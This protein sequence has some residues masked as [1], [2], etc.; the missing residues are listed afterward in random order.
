MFFPRRRPGLAG[1]PPLLP[2]AWRAAPPAAVA[3]A[4]GLCALMPLLAFSTAVLAA[5]EAG[6]AWRR[7]REGLA[8][9]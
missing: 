2:G 3:L 1:L 5:L 9:A 7:R 6:L 4:I 8:A